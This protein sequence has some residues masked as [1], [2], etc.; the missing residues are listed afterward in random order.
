MRQKSQILSTLCLAKRNIYSTSS[1][2][3]PAPSYLLHKICT[4]PSKT[5]GVVCY[6]PAFE[7]LQNITCGIIMSSSGAF[8]VQL[9]INIE[10]LMCPNRP[11]RVSM[12]WLTEEHIKHHPRYLTP[13][14]FL[15]HT[16]LLR[17][18]NMIIGDTCSALRPFQKTI[19]FPP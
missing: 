7:E 8:C 5:F 11:S 17:F 9:Q 15:Y 6:V 19:Q 10:P 2:I 4:L 13:S 12:S 1:T 18:Q 14:S 3:H 16:H